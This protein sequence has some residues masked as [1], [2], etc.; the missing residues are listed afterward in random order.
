MY[1]LACCTTK[2]LHYFLPLPSALFLLFAFFSTKEPVSMC[3]H[4]VRHPVALPRPSLPS[5]HT[6]RAA[7][8]F[9]LMFT[10]HTSCRSEYEHTFLL[11]IEYGQSSL[12]VFL[13][14]LGSNLNHHYY[15]SHTHTST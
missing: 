5:A 12:A 4:L 9:V 6:K 7:T 13:I 3:A 1:I 2:G 14:Q 10:M 8:M 15:Y 11:A